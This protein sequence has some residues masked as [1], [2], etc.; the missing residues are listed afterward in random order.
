MNQQD[1]QV[2]F[3]RILVALDASYHSLAALEA[4]VELAAS[5]QA[6]LEGLFVEDVNLLRAAGSPVAREVL[7][8]FT[9]AARLEPERVERGLRAQ[10]EQGRQALA[11]ASEQR[12]IRWSFRVV[13]G[14]VAPEVSRPL[15]RQIRLGS[16]ALAAAVQAPCCVLLLRRD[17]GVRPPI[18]VTYDGSPTAR[19][20]LRIATQLAQENGNYLAVLMVASTPDEEYKLQAQTAD[21]LRRQGLLIRYR[22]LAEASVATLAQAMLSEGKGVLVLSSAIL[23]PAELQELLDEVD[24]PVLLVR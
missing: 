10:A 2:R 23:P 4:A 19:R 12:E 17:M 21:W 3:R 14:E 8:P 24:F 7:Y 15:V 1:D 16:T 6:E 5:M 9:D 11:A 18:V 13:R 22:R 20:A